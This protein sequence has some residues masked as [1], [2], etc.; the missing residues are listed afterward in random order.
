MA[1]CQCNELLS[2]H[3]K[4]DTSA[5]KDGI[6]PTRGHNAKRLF[7]LSSVACIQ[8]QNALTARLRCGQDFPGLKGRSFGIRVY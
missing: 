7:N 2:V 8:N 5:V 6:D 1:R 4:E 3:L